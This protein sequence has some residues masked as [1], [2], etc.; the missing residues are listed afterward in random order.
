VLRFFWFVHQIGADS[1]VPIDGP[2]TIQ[3]LKLSRGVS[4]AGNL[5]LSIVQEDSPPSQRYSAIA[6]RRESG[7][8]MS[9]GVMRADNV[10]VIA[11]EPRSLF[12]GG[13]RPRVAR[14]LTV[15][16]VDVPPANDRGH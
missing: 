9:S 7:M 14:K 3:L 4:F 15:E 11:G 13:L 10:R 16:D 12:R 5:R 6:E 1:A 8:N 2:V